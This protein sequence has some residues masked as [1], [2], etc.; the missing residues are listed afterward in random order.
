MKG[1]DDRVDRIS[2]DANQKGESYRPIWKKLVT[3][4]RAAEGLRE[5]WRNHLRV[6][7]SEIGFEYLRFH[8]I[9][10]DEMMIFHQRKDGSVYYNWQYLDSLFDFLLSVRIRPFLELGFTPSQLASGTATVFWWKGNTTPPKDFDAW[11]A[12]AKELVI[13]CI[14]RYG[15]PEVLQWY[16]EVWNEPNISFWAGTQAEYFNLYDKCAAVL[17]SV[18]PRLRVGGPASSAPC[19]LRERKAPWVE[20]FLAHGEEGGI[21]IDFVSAHPYP[22]NWQFVETLKGD[23]MRYGDEDSTRDDLR[24]LQS[25]VRKSDFANAEIHVTEWNSSP[26]PR[27]LAHDTA[28]MCPFIIRNNLRCLG[29][30]DSLGFWTFTDVF[31]E[32]GAGDEIFHGGFGLINYQGLKKAAYYGYWFLARLGSEK[33]ASGDNYFLARKEGRIQILLWNY[34]HYNEAFSN[35]DQRGLSHLDR[36]SI[37]DGAP[38][39]LDVRVENLDGSYKVVTHRLG[40]EHGN[41]YDVWLKN[42]ALPVPTAEDLEIIRRESGPEGTIRLLEDARQFQARI[43]LEPHDVVM[44]ELERQL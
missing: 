4:G 44:I 19:T 20:E 33:I 14:N 8:G 32:T 17:K 34:C 40:R 36:Y 23:V 5:D 16:F 10:H 18:D 1:K 30:A 21:P 24:W 39:T 22:N 26:S 42:G 2:I 9:F 12:M 3:A 25:T 11:C 29:L 37:F 28:F 35:G 6:L 7:Q 41:A 38:T 13:H 31:E 15:L 27:D 43:V